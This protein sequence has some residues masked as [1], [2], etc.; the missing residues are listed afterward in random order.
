MGIAFR[1]INPDMP[2]ILRIGY[3][4]IVLSFVMTGISL[5][6]KRHT[7]ENV[8]DGESGRRKIRLGAMMIAF[9]MLAGIGMSFFVRQFKNIALEAGY[10]I[11]AGFILLGIIIIL[12]NT[13]KKMDEKG[14]LIRERIFETT[15]VF[16]IAA[17]GICGILAL[18]YTVFW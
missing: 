8:P 6:D 2:F 5:L 17:I 16:N 13:Q 4:F 18:L 10:V 9:A 15:P 3:V 12:N 11:V 7:T 14:I 1:I